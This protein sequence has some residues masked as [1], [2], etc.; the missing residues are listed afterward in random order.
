MPIITQPSIITSTT[1]IS[2]G[3]IVDDD[4]SASAAIAWSKISKTGSSLADLASRAATDLTGIL[5]VTKGGTGV[6]TLTANRLIVGNGSNP[7]TTIAPGASGTVLTSNGTAWVASAAPSSLLL[8]NHT[9]ILHTGT[10]A[11]TT[12]RSFTLPGGSIGA[13]GA[14]RIRIEYR[15]LG[16][17]GTKTV[18]IKFGGTTVYQMVVPQGSADYRIGNVTILNRNSESAQVYEANPSYTKNGSTVSFDTADVGSDTRTMAV[19]TATNTTIE[20]TGQLAN[21][22]DTI[23]LEAVSIWVDKKS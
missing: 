13:N 18:R 3:V 4:I 5:P 17:G 20:V 9:Q 7:V 14:C 16:G 15:T 1:Q 23:R 2:S 12:L 11:E 21:A 6:D 19:D 8:N 22:A 10:T